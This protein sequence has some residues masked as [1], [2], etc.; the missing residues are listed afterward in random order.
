MLDRH[1]EQLDDGE[2]LELWSA[3]ATA[4]SVRAEFCMILD[5]ICLQRDHFRASPALDLRAFRARLLASA[6]EEDASAEAFEAA[7]VRMAGA[8]DG[9]A[10]DALRALF[11]GLG[12]T[13]RQ[14]LCGSV[15]LLAARGS[16]DHVADLC[17]AVRRSE[18][19]AFALVVRGASRAAAD[20]WDASDS[21]FDQPAASAALDDLSAPRPLGG[22][23]SVAF[24]KRCL[25]LYIAEHKERAFASA[26]VEPAKFY[27]DCA[28]DGANR[29]LVGPRG[30]QW[31]L[32]ALRAAFGFELP[33]PFAASEAPPGG[34]CDPWAA[35]SDDVWRAFSDPDH[36]G[37][38][39][40]AIAALE[41]PALRRLERRL[42]PGEY[43]AGYRAG[44]PRDLGLAAVGPS[45]AVREGLVPGLSRFAHFFSRD[46]F[47]PKAFEALHGETDKRYAG[48]RLAA[49]EAF[50]RFRLALGEQFVAAE[51]LDA[52]A[53]GAGGSFDRSAVSTL[54]WW[55]GAT[56]PQR[57]LAVGPVAGL[58][59]HG[60]RLLPFKSARAARSRMSPA[61]KRRQERQAG[62]AERPVHALKAAGPEPKKGRKAFWSRP[63][64]EKKSEIAA[65]KSEKAQ[66]KNEIAKEKSEKRTL[67]P[68][69]SPKKAPRD[70]PVSS[71]GSESG[72]S[73][74]S[75]LSGEPDLDV[76]NGRNG[77][78]PAEANAP[79]RALS[80]GS[81]ARLLSAA[82]GRG[83]R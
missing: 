19:E 1:Q 45:R 44:T 25:A 31:Y 16:A 18:A 26:F 37:R 67:W 73:V 22:D 9:A 12:T 35:L 57:N 32:A 66:E 83:R 2:L 23:E 27:F 20:Q 41:S 74:A 46:F 52:F 43:P 80:M 56:V 62:A 14:V 21:E 34:L 82:M 39:F 13:D 4:E 28:R 61:Q 48:F 6:R 71:A 10:L 17:A 50:A 3:P 59:A 70:A 79:R 53:K 65:K 7:A 77:G 76:S 72:A 15:R 33:L 40:R 24:V 47:V 64:P 5:G 29:D 81:P 55:L 51:T 54:L 75:A 8:G 49:Q 11:Q 78:G 63:A 60:A 58:E 38:D 42:K 30:S 36:F 68:L 69:R